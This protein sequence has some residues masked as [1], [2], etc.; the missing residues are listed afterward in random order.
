MDKKSSMK[1]N[2][3]SDMTVGSPSKL[4]I[5]FAFP[6]LIGNLFQQLYN[7]VDAV[8]VGKFSGPNGANALAAVGSVSSLNF[9]I[10][11][12]TM[13]LAAGIGIVISQFFGAKDYRNV[14]RGFSTATYMLIV[15]SF[16]MGAIGFLFSRTFLE[17]LNTPAGI[18][19]DANIYFKIC[20]LGIMGN[21][22]YNGMAA[23][24]RALGDSITPLIFLIVACIVNIVLDL[25]FVIVFHL[26]VP[27][28]AYA[29]I[30][31]QAVSGIGCII[32]GLKKVEILRMP[33]REFIPHKD[34]MKKCITLGLPAAL[35][36]S[37]V[38]IS[39]IVIQRVTNQ[40]GET[41]IAAS[42]AAARLEQ[43]VLQP[44]MSLG[45]A[46]ANYTGQN[47]GADRIDR[48]KQG[49]W[50]A[51]KIITIFSLIM[52]PLVSFG[53]ESIMRLF[54][55]EPAVSEIGARAIRVTSLFYI[56]VGMIYVSRNL[57][58]GAGDMK[59]PMIMGV[60]E[61]FCRVFFA[62]VLTMIPAIGFMG[63][64]WASGLN[65][66]FTGSIGCL[67]YATGKW[68][69]KSVVMNKPTA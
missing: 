9:V 19:E 32:Y 7:M 57:L 1:N 14:A 66:F 15:V 68:K 48:A 6:M 31:A 38:A 63:I 40:Y 20:C 4:L 65:W 64:W 3:V 13:G 16:V 33:I 37:F 42:T 60:S 12:L 2:F 26:G 35:Q 29:T 53:G 8:V 56:P 25:L 44:G 27:G 46:L 21:T 36:N 54:T 58:S 55:D 24:M 28:V 34:I 69:N 5:K 45:L 61:V 49:F 17:L 18:I 47:I 39:T 10:F 41:V 50:A 62:N 59:I 52:T 30:I 51:T 11:S 22:A 43:L 23:V 67:R